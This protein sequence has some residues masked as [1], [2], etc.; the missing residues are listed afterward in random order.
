MNGNIYK[1]DNTDK[2][3]IIPDDKSESHGKLIIKTSKGLP[4]S[5]LYVT[6]SGVL[7][8]EFG[9]EPAERNVIQGAR[10]LTVGSQNSCYAQDCMMLGTGLD[11]FGAPSFSTFLG[12]YND[13]NNLSDKILVIGNGSYSSRSTALTVDKSGNLVCNNIPAAPTTD[14]NYVLKCSIVGGVPTYSWVAEQ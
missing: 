3:V 5:S 14:G 6:G 12:G 11:N 4:D 1:I 7:D 2:M 10:S 9:D 8:V 13:K